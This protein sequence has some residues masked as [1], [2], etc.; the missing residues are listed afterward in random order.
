[1]RCVVTGAAG[2][3]GSHLC[4]LL[5]VAGRRGDRDR[6]L[7]RL[8]RPATQGDQPVGALQDDGF[9][10]H[11]GD[12]SGRR[13][14]NCS[15]APT[16][17]STSPASRGAAVV[18]R[19]LRDLRLAQ[20]LGHATAARGGAGR[21]ARKLVYASSSRV[22]GTRSRYPTP[23]SLRPPPS[24][25]TAS[26]SWPPSTCASS[27]GWASGSRR[28]LSGSS[29]F[30]AHDSVRTWPSPGWSTRRFGDERSSCT[31]SG[32]QTRDFTYVA[33]RRRRDAQRGRSTFTG[34]ANIGG[35]SGPR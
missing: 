24:R 29:P 7:H 2:F 4:E 17:C 11:R 34:V 13:S 32:T 31:A 35:G 25:P 12:L 1:M 15:T 19:R 28:C 10:L 23:E 9:R 26:P 6:L 20:R 27:T 3:V 18:G 8:L 5:A 22:Y 30:T 14:A 21:G 16:S 33:G